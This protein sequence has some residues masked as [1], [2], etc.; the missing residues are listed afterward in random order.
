MKFK[1]VNNLLLSSSV[2]IP[3][4]SIVS[5]QTIENKQINE[6]NNENELEENVF[7]LNSNKIWSPS[8]FEKRENAFEIKDGDSFKKELLSQIKIEQVKNKINTE[9]NDFIKTYSKIFNSETFKKYHVVYYS[10]YSSGESLD[11]IKVTSENL[12]INFITYNINTKAV[13]PR[14]YIIFIEKTKIPVIKTININ[15]IRTRNKY[16]TYKNKLPSK[17]QIIYFK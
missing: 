15:E 14:Q 10:N 3:V 12:D 4:F 17:Q 11:T 9:W 1:I 16:L 6:F 8:D 5:C 2:W 7:L 13:Y